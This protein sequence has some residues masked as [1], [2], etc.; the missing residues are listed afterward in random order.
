MPLIVLA[1]MLLLVRKME[2][3]GHWER[4]TSN[5]DT[6]KHRIANYKALQ[7]KTQAVT[8]HT[9][10]S[11][12]DLGIRDSLPEDVNFFLAHLDTTKTRQRRVLEWNLLGR[13]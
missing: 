12:C 5:D 3:T 7:E 8:T 1:A 4:Q 2:F 9:R 13:E 11:R 10:G 6:D